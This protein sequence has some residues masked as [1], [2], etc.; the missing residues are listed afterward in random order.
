MKEAFEKAQKWLKDPKN[1]TLLIVFLLLFFYLSGLLA[2]F[3]NNRYGWYPGEDLTLP[4]PNPLK[5]LAMLFTPFGAQ[6]MGGLFCFLLIVTLLAWINLEDRS[7]I[8]YDKARNF[9]YSNK[10]VYGTAGWMNDQE[11]RACFDV[12]PEERAVEVTEII[13]GIKDGMVVSRKAN[14]RLGP[15][16]R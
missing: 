4:S 10:G 13:Y 11:L 3:L 7:G 6:A 5:S 1:K 14:T 2:Q 12:T 15:Q 8:V 9:W 16:S